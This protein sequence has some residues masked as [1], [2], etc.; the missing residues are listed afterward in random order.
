MFEQIDEFK[1][2]YFGKVFKKQK[3]GYWSNKI[4][5]QRWVWMHYNGTIPKG[6]DIHHIDHDKSNNDISNLQMLSRSDHLKEHWK[7][8]ECRAKRRVFLDKIRP[9]VHE[10]LRSEEGRKKQ[11]IEAIKGWKKR[12]SVIITCEQCQQKIYTK[13]PQQRFCCDACDK[14]WRRNQKLYL[15]EVIC[16]ICNKLFIK[17]KWTPRRFC[18]LSCGYKSSSIK[19]RKAT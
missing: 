17:T 3:D 12:K 6:M 10:W 11:S 4:H 18:S 5:A 2:N 9:K 13:T 16:P 1:R 8:P 15:I 19:R 7:N 14:K